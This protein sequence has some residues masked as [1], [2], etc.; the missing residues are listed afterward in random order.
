MI[1]KLV[2]KIGDLLRIYAPYT[3]EI[4]KRRIH[5]AQHAIE[6]QQIECAMKNVAL[7]NAAAMSDQVG[8]TGKKDRRIGRSDAK[9]AK[10]I[11]LCGAH[12]AVPQ[13][14]AHTRRRGRR[15]SRVRSD[16]DE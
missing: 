1:P 13:V 5:G 3:F 10:P 16:N 14:I 15:A 2:M 12:A 7:W 6:F 8:L 9:F 4:D 11:R